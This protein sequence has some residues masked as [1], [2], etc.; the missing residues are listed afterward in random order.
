MVEFIK[1]KKLTI[2]SQSIP[3]F[4]EGNAAWLKLGRRGS[5]EVEIVSRKKDEVTGKYVYQVKGKEGALHNDGEWMAQ[6]KLDPA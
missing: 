4:D 2:V 3:K 5:F 6:E 1:A